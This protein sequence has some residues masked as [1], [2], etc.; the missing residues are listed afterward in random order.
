M[1]RER[2][3]H[4]KEFKDMALW[5]TSGATE[6]YEWQKRGTSGGRLG[7]SKFANLESGEIQTLNLRAES[8]SM[9]AR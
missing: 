2:Q 6:P 5:V 1:E 9:L 8:M 4:I 3:K 7:A